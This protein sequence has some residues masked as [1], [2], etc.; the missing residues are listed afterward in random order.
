[1]KRQLT[2]V[3]FL[4]VAGLMANA[5]K[6]YRIAKANGNLRLN[7]NGATIEGYDGK[8]IIFSIQNEV[9]QKLDDRAKGLVALSPS[10]LTD[11]TGMGFSILS[12]GLDI[13]VDNVLKNSYDILKIMVPK[14]I[15]IFVNNNSN[16]FYEDFIIR[17]MAGEIEISTSYNKIRLE[18]NSGPMNISS[19]NGAIEATFDRD[20]KGPIS[21]VSIYD[22]VDITLPATTKANIEMVTFYGKLYA[23]KEFSIEPDLAE[24]AKTSQVQSK[25]SKEVVN[26]AGK[27]IGG[28]QINKNR[29][30][31]PSSLAIGGSVGFGQ[32]YSRAEKIK[33][34][35]NGGGL[36]LII[37]SN[38]QN[39]YLRNK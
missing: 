34:K 21:I 39:I 4:M 1:M 19:I 27:N 10:G 32:Q 38:N 37:R 7:I 22:Y 29:Q 12:N 24:A 17:N 23:A 28:T 30:N 15:K 36:D 2:I 33:G 9:D 20:I 18:N 3:F 31:S 13:N 14:G 26:T 35:L 11:N 25:G 6:E 8:E 16:Q 5:Q